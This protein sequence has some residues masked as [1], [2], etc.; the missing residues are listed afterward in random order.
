MQDFRSLL[1]GLTN[2]IVKWKR[3]ML[4]FGEKI[5]LLLRLP[6]DSVWGDIRDSFVAYLIN[7]DHP[8]KAVVEWCC[9]RVFRFISTVVVCNNVT[10]CN[11]A[12]VVISGSIRIVG[13]PEQ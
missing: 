5:V 13:F 4:D 3:L 2:R 10:S 1:L 12:V 6:G 7:F 8:V 9:E 11:N